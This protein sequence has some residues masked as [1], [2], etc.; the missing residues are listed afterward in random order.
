MT[1]SDVDNPGHQRARSGSEGQSQI[2][3]RKSQI[4][5]PPSPGFAFL[6]RLRWRLLVNGLRSFRRGSLL[7]A[8]VVAVGGVAFWLGILAASYYGFCFINRYLGHGEPELLVETLL[9]MFFLLLG[10][11][12][13]FSN[14]IIAFGTLFRSDETEFLLGCPVAAE[15]VFGYRLAEALTFSSWAFLVLGVPLMLGYGLSV[16]VNLPPEYL[17]PSVDEVP[18]LAPEVMRH[19]EASSVTPWYYPLAVVAYFVPFVLVPAAAGGMVALVLAAYLPDQ[20]KRVLGWSAVAGVVAAVSL[21]LWVHGAVES[22]SMFSTRWLHSVLGRMNFARNMFMPSYWVTQGLLACARGRLAETGYWLAVLASTAAMGVVACSE[23]GRRLLRVA[24]SR[25]RSHTSQRRKA[26]GGWAL[27]RWAP[28]MRLLVSKDWRLFVRDPVQWSQCA[29]L[30]GLMGFYVMNLRSFAYQSA[31]PLWRNLTALLNLTATSL[32]LATVTTRFIFP[33]LSLE[34]RRFWLLGLAPVTRRTLLWAK[35]L[36]SF[37]AALCVTVPLIFLSDF[38]LKLPG[39]TTAHHLAATVLICFGVSGM[40]VGLG[41]VYPNWREENPS[42]IV[43]GFGGTLN[44]LLSI[45]FVFGVVT[46]TVVPYALALRRLGE[47]GLVVGSEA[48]WG[49]AASALLSLAVGL[50][51]MHLGLRSLRR[52]EF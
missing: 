37:V 36:L 14:A 8:A 2:G 25:S 34:G 5:P 35:F 39:S 45:A 27:A 13:L 12:L 23:L 17:A 48:L 20:V 46:L 51:P 38:M 9:S 1:E 3:N 10:A 52:L 24:W 41:A 43:S 33:L 18:T 6:L 19:L 30:F 49:V 44:L 21:V 15:A 26:S 16:G 7:K 4:A 22:G 47:G 31:Q 50:L 42:K 29:I 11:M 40:S 28:P 32:V